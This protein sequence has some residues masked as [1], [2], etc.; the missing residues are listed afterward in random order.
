MW[1]LIR[2]ERKIQTKYFKHKLIKYY[3]YVLVNKMRGKKVEVI[4]YDI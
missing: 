4:K 1:V 3:L 2:E